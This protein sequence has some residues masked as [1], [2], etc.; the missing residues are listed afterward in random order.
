MQ[1]KDSPQ[2]DLS[3]HQARL[4]L[5]LSP[6]LKAHLESPANSSNYKMLAFK[7]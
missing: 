5:D 7:L 1:S 6:E 2:P 4:L 3:S